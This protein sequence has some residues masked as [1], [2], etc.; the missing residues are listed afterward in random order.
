MSFAEFDACVEGWNR[1]H[2]TQ[3]TQAPSDEEF[4]EALRAHGMIA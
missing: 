2:G 1:V 3:T 4:D